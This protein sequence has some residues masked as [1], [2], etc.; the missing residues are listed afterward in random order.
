MLFPLRLGQDVHASLTVSVL[1]R[2]IK[3]VLIPQASKD[4]LIY[5]SLNKFVHSYLTAF[6][7]TYQEPVCGVP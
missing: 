4:S 6:F 5:T 3:K 7:G 2:S 1:Q